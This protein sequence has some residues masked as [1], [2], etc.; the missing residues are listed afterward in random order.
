ME[1]FESGSETRKKDGRETAI[2]N[3]ATSLLEVDLV[4]SQHPLMAILWRVDIRKATILASGIKNRETGDVG[5]DANLSC[6]V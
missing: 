5:L 4:G 3:G 6:D 2:R 1:N